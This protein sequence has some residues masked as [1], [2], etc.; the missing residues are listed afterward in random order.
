MNPSLGSP[1]P[2]TPSPT[3]PLARLVLRTL[4]A[5]QRYFRSRSKE[6]LIAS[7]RLEMELMRT[8]MAALSGG[9]GPACYCEPGACQAKA[10]ECLRATECVKETGMAG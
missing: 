7:K 4:Q 10:G 8:A 9:Y 1:S 3:I 2:A 6:D 5:Q